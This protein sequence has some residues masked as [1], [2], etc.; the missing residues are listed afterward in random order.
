MSALGPGGSTLGIA[1]LLSHSEVS[2]VMVGT[3]RREQLAE[4]VKSVNWA[5]TPEEAL[6]V[7]HGLR[8][9]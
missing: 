3:R 4:N 5:L 6:G 9:I 8:G 2:A 1:W 7:R